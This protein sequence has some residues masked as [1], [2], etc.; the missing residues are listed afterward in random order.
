MRELV[1]KLFPIEPSEAE[2]FNFQLNKQ[3]LSMRDIM[4][5]ACDPGAAHDQVLVQPGKALSAPKHM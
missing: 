1:L 5:T 4:Q 2:H 3:G